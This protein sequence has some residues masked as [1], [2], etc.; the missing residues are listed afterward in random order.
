MKATVNVAKEH[1]DG[2]I[3]DLDNSKFFCLIILIL[4]ELICLALRLRL[5]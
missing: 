2:I 1:I 4:L 5:D 3:K